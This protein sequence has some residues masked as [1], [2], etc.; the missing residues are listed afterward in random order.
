MRKR[1]K[2]LEQRKANSWKE[3]RAFENKEQNAPKGLKHVR[4]SKTARKGLEQLRTRS[5]P[6]KKEQATRTGHGHLRKRSKPLERD[7]MAFQK[8][9]K[10]TIALENRRK[11]PRAFEKTKQTA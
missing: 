5:K 11:P 6:Q 7:Y 2:G 3:T 9:R 1:R 4:K 10:R 8:R